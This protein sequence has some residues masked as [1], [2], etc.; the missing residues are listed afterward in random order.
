MVDPTQ[1]E[2]VVDDSR[3]WDLL[4]PSEVKMKHFCKR[5]EDRIE[6]DKAL[7]G[8]KDEL[9]GEVAGIF[10]EGKLLL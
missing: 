9:K 4:T 5:I 7:P 3:V 1:T 6:Q 10:K 2:S 8:D